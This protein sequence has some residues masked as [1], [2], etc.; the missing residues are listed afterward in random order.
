MLPVNEVKIDSVTVNNIRFGKSICTKMQLEE[1]VTF[2]DSQGTHKAY[3]AETAELAYMGRMGFGT[4]GPSS[5]V[6]C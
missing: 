4:R 2:Q 3:L 6:T 1:F 5:V